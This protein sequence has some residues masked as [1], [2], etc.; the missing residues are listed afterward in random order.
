MEL[1]EVEKE[2][3]CEVAGVFEI[4][5]GAYNFRVNGK[6]IGRKS[7][8]NIEI[9]TKKEKSGLDIY[10]KKGTKNEQVHIPVAISVTGLKEVVYNDFYI[11]D[12]AEVTII[13]GCGIYN[14]GGLDALHDG[15]HRFF[16]GKKAK[17]KYIERHYG[18]G[19][20]PGG[21]ILN[22][23]TEVH[24][25]E[26]AEAELLME[27]IKGVDSTIRKTMAD[28]KDGA[29]LKVEERLMTHG[30][31][32]AESVYEVKLDGV[33]ATATVT[34]RSIA[35]DFSRQTFK[36]K[37]IGNNKCRGHSECDAIIMDQAQVF[38]IPSLEA[39]NVEAELIHEAAIGK[40][41]SEQIIKLMTLGLEKKAAEAKI[42]NGFLK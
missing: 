35:Q 17:I 19:K 20:G 41:A 30:R 10:I 38:A 4:P 31:Q 40:I 3:F 22:P 18:F 13:A 42:I 6:S 21:K 36:A 28:L 34:S 15:I 32:V 7:S 26:G 39:K 2:I 27:Q 5:E 24:L 12:E 37:I 9:K 23:T 1:K 16:V 25:A 29:K 8:E 14:C 33:D 11:G